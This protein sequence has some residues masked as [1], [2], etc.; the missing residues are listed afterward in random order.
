MK[1]YKHF[2]FDIDG[3]IIDNE[4]ANLLAFQRALQDEGIEKALPDLRFSLGI[5]GKVSMAQLGSADC[6]AAVRRWGEYYQ[7]FAA[8]G[9][10]KPFNGITDVLRTLKAGGYTMGIVT[11]K[12]RVEYLD[13]FCKSWDFAALFDGYICADDTAN[14][15][16]HAEPLLAVLHQ[17]GIKAADTLY[18]GDSIYDMQCANSAGVDFGAAMWGAV[19]PKAFTNCAVKPESPADILLYR[20]AAPID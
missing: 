5:P 20:K 9:M 2:V 4:T 10:I 6:D 14:P 19:S 18:L 11:S 12:N 1:Q 16:P 13:E 17:L 15:K 3:T 7:Q 8:K